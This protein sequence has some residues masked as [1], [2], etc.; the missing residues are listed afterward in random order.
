MV[1][2]G[3]AR[4]GVCG[5]ARRVYV[6][7]RWVLFGMVRDSRCGYARYGVVRLGK[8]RGSWFG[9]SQSGQVT[10]GESRLG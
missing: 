7:H 4:Y 2:L 3:L 6:G 10:S 1:R 9:K 8:V 5:A